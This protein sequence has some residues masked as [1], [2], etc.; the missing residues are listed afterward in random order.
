MR[1]STIARIVI[2]TL[3]VGWVSAALVVGGLM[4]L[5]YQE[6]VRYFPADQVVAQFQAHLD[7]EVWHGSLLLFVQIGILGCALWWQIVRKPVPPR[8]ALLC[9]VIVALAQ[10]GI[11]WLVGVPRLFLVPLVISLVV[12]G[13]LAGEFND[14]PLQT[15]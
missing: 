2:I 14:N 15:S 8:G 4:L 6:V 12:I 7:R 3:L 9:G 13:W 11:G 10:A 1:I 5:Q